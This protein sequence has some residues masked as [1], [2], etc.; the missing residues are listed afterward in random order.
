VRY[1]NLVIDPEPL[2]RELLDWLGEPWSLG[3]LEHHNVQSARGGRLQVEGRSRVDDPIDVSR[4]SKWTQRMTE[5]QRAVLRKRLGALGG[6]LGYN[7]DDPIALLPLR[8]GALVANGVDL[9]ARIDQHAEL[10]LR[11][12][13]NRPIADRFYDPRVSQIR[14]REAL[15]ELEQPGWLRRIALIAWRRIPPARRGQLRPALRRARALIR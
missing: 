14:S 9:D 15:A 11:R 5:P 10:D 7:V 3:V 2:L 4:V 6:F 8:D 13:N 12:E 1:E